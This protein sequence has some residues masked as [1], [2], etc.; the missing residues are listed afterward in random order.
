QHQLDPNLVKSYATDYCGVKT[1]REAKREQVEAFVVHLRAATVIAIS[2][3]GRKKTAGQ[4]CS[5][6]A[7]LNGLWPPTF[8]G[9]T[10]RLPCFR[11]G[12]SV[13][14]RSSNTRMATA[15]TACSSKAFNCSTASA[16][17]VG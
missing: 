7:P 1:L 12:S 14:I 10:R 11:N 13:R 9:K 3:A 6:G 4:P 5:S 17:R 8:S 2:M 15:G 16:R